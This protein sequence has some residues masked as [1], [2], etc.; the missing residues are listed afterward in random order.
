MVIRQVRLLETIPLYVLHGMKFSG[1]FHI[2]SAASIVALY[3]PM[4]C[5]AQHYSHV[6]FIHPPFLAVRY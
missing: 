2:S 3:L 6:S 5:L 4:Y 1:G